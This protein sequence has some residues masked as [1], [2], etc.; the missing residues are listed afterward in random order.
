[1]I[2]LLR[3]G[4]LAAA[5]GFALPLSA[6]EATPAKPASTPAKPA[7]KPTPAKP[8]AAKP[9]AKPAEAA[10]AA[11]P[12]AKPAAATAKPPAAPKPAPAG[13]SASAQ[14]TLL[15][16]YGEWGAYAANPNGRKVCFALA[17]P[18]SSQ[19]N[20]A[21]R[22]RDPAYVF[23]SSRPAEKVKDEVSVVIGYAF[24]PGS[25]A[26]AE[27]GSAAF[28]LYTQNDGAWLK[29]AAEESRLVEAMRKGSDMVVKGQSS[30]GTQSTDRFTL[31]GL[32]QALDRVAQECR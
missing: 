16:Q 31:K 1:M 10:P 5:L 7:A 17:K 21:N 29:N 9:A 28:P 30:R 4:L 11:K 20:P 2:G 19:T 12:A 32:A 6:Q 14:P 24:K 25:D 18:S 8:A 22:P 3:F 13:A 15:G 23:I 26:S 27:I